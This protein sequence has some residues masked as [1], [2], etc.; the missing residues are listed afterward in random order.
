M[1]KLLSLTLAV[2]MVLATLCVGASAFAAEYPSGPV[3]FI[4]PYGEGGGKDI[5]ARGFT[6]YL[7]DA[8]GADIVVENRPGSSGAVGAQYVQ[9]KDA[10]GYTLYFGGEAVET[11]PVMGLLD[12]GYEA[13]QPVIVLNRES[14]TLM[15]NPKSEFAGMDWAQFIE[16]VKEHPGE[17]S[18]G[19][20]GIGSVQWNWMKL[21]QL[22]YGIEFL[23]VS[24][25]SGT[26]AI[27]ALLG[28]HIDIYACGPSQAKGYVESGD[29]IPVCTMD[30]TPIEGFGC[31]CLADYTDAFDA[32]LPYGS[33]VV[34]MAKA[35]TDEAVYAKL[36]ES[37][38]AAWS[39]EGFQSFLTDTNKV[40]P[41][42][43][44]GDEA[45]AY[46]K[47]AQAIT[48]Y[49]LYDAGELATDPATLGIE[50]VG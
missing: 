10:D 19:S 11:Y 27:T 17:V 22:V 48:C 20:T 15:F 36:C 39:T 9:S 21:L 13:W 37:A 3:T 7:K 49:L 26:A 5:M 38:Y 4:V 46:V 2:A 1:K 29:L 18:F 42:G 33:Y 12:V 14:P 31:P 30:K 43:V 23:E 44:T 32:Y 41:V 8:L 40:V 35:G 50:R 34:I 24:Y 6:P 47:K 28:G 25:E 45:L 16:Y